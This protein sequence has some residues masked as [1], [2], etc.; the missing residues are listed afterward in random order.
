[1]KK[2]F[3]LALFFCL[4]G[5]VSWAQLV[6]LPTR[7]ALIVTASTRGSTGPSLVDPLDKGNFFLNEVR[8]YDALREA[9]FEAKNIRV[10]YPATPD[11]GETMEVLGV[12]RLLD[13]QFGLWHGGYDHIATAENIANALMKFGK[14]VTRNDIFV[15][16][17]GTHGA[18]DS[19]EIEAG[20]AEAY[21]SWFQELLLNI[22]PRFGLFYSDAC[23][24]GVFIRALNLPDFIL[25]STTGNALGW[26]D[27]HYSGA[28]YFFQSL[29][30]GEADT[31]V[32]GKIT[33]EEAYWRSQARADSH[34]KRINEYLRTKYNYAGMGSYED[35]F[36]NTKSFWHTSVE[37]TMIVGKNVSSD[38]SFYNSF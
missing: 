18:E 12:Q 5:S 15:M 16:Y 6:P 37:Q 19:V 9:G 34:M 22:H 32:D 25:V 17:L 11:W 38:F 1:M 21:V 24:S 13:E 31:N 27:R 20:N 33:I 10:L 29:V 8:V 4:I 26:A 30:D 7:Y 36:V 28:A 35:S 23:H 2:V 3:C 14:V